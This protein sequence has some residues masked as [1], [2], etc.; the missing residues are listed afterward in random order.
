MLKENKVT[1]NS[2]KKSLNWLI[3]VWKNNQIS[4]IIYSSTINR[5]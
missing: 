1:E 5:Y 3:L 2:K 4:S